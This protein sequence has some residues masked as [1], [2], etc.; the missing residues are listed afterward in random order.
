MLAKS[1]RA[2]EREKMERDFPALVKT[3]VRKVPKV[4]SVNIHWLIEQCSS[5]YFF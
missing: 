3:E 2:L 1:E 5:L 4:E